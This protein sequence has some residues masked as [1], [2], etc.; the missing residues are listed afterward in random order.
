[1]FCTGCGKEAS[2]SDAFCRGCDRPLSDTKPVQYITYRAPTKGI[3]LSVGK[4]LAIVFG[5]VF[6][7]AVIRVATVVNEQPA[8]LARTE[9]SG[10]PISLSV[11]NDAELLLSRCGVADKDWSTQYDDPRPPIVTRFIT[12]NKAHLKFAYIPGGGSKVY[13]PPPYTWKMIGI[14]DTRTNKAITAEHLKST[15]KKRLACY[16]PN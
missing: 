12:Y 6:L 7:G 5:V 13:D 8:P 11:G 9:S 16:L 10:R 14:I 1:V 4:I 2:A 15:L 3:G